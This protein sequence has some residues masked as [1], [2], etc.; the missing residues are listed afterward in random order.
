MS[1]QTESIMDQK[2][3]FIRMWLSND[4]TIIGLCKSF[5]ISRTTGYNLI[6][7]YNQIGDSC[8]ESKSTRPHK[9]PNRTPRIIEEKIVQL[10]T[11]HPDW[12]ARKFKTLL[13]KYFKNNLIPSETT[14]NAILKR[15]NLVVNRRKRSAGVGKLNPQFDPKQCNEIWSAD[16]KGKFKIGN[17]RY[18]CPLTVCDSKSRKILGINC[19]Y[20]ATY[21]SVK[22]AY[23][24]IFRQHGLPSF[25]HTD[26]GSPFGNTQALCR[27]TKLCY[28]LIDQQIIPIFSDPASPQQN[29]RHERMHRDLKAFCRKKI[30]NTLSKQQKVLDE[31]KY[32]YNQ[33]RPHEAL[34]MKT[35]NSVHVRSI[36]EYS[37]TKIK[38]DYDFHYKKMKVCINGAARWGA[39]HW[40][41]IGAG[42]AGRY[43]AAQE[44]GNGIWN[45]YYRNV[46]L[47]YFDENF[48]TRKQQYQKLTNLKV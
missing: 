18:C 36:K 40:L 41:F 33:I 30:K 23:V 20:K 7:A 19:H 13:E 46:L 26:N 5:G 45:V 2:E 1:W 12:G 32:E 11:K 44:V 21:K 17:G 34:K 39:Y 28:W 42:A 10:R 48:F 16:Y 14:I 9:S 3:R 37:E 43:V 25:I 15:N 6:E 4:F 31:F 38:Y 24:E 22:Q 29:G 47:G 35:P 27:F 8:F